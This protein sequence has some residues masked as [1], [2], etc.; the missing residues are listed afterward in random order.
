[1]RLGCF[2]FDNG[3]N[4]QWRKPKSLLIVGLMLNMKRITGFK[5][6][7]ISVTKLIYSVEVSNAMTKF[8]LITTM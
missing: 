8:K 7:K 4:K 6:K 5:T 3:F 2:Y 1:M